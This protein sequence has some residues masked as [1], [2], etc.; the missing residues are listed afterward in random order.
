[1][2]EQKRFAGR[3]LLTF[4]SQKLNY[5][6]KKRGAGILTLQCNSYL[7]HVRFFFKISSNFLFLN[8]LYPL[9]KMFFQHTFISVNNRG[10]APSKYVNKLAIGFYFLIPEAKQ[11]ICI[12]NTN[13][14]DYTIFCAIFFIHLKPRVKSFWGV[15][16]CC[17]ALSILFSFRY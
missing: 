14:Y 3:H 15:L 2:F 6:G 13:V 4:E 17:L 11:S 10:R 12:M 1:M 16:S 5:L 8:S 9:S 7:S